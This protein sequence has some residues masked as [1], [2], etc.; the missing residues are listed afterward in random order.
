HPVN[1]VLFEIARRL[2]EKIGLKQTHPFQAGMI[3]E[4]QGLIRPALNP[5]LKGQLKEA[6][7]RRVYVGIAERDGVYVGRWG[8]IPKLYTDLELAHAYY[9]VYER[10]SVVV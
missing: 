5:C 2:A 1:R 6:S 4:L 10:N 9:A 3:G 8:T 7:S